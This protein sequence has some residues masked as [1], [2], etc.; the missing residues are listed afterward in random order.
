MDQTIIL[1]AKLLGYLVLATSCLFMGCH[2]LRMAWKLYRNI[3]G[4]ALA[5]AAIREY[6]KTHPEKF[7]HFDATKLK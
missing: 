5:D 2:A 6:R 3:I 4:L 1:T 7:K